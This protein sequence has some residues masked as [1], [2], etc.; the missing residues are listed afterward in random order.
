MG[1]FAK[2]EATKM[3]QTIDV[4]G[5][6]TLSKKE[7]KKFL[8]AQKW[9]SFITSESFTWAG[10][11]EEYGNA[12]GQID[13]KSFDT[14]YA[15]KL[16]PLIQEFEEASGG[17]V[18]LVPPVERPKSP[19]ATPV[20]LSPGGARGEWDSGKLSKSQKKK[21]AKERKAAAAAA[22]ANVAVGVGSMIP[23]NFNISAASFTPTKTTKTATTATSD[24]T[25]REEGP[26]PTEKVEKLSEG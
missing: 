20:K 21:A 17:P 22:A 24:A 26:A 3:F 15:L 9:G 5:D 7:L 6:L 19:P 8:K 13:P 2:S 16:R 14:L 10:F 12:E 1:A 25:L 11:F 18:D 23:P 4:D